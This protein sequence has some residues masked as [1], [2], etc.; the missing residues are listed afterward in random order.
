MLL[1]KLN[2]LLRP[3]SPCP[4]NKSC[5][6]GFLNVCLVGSESVKVKVFD[7]ISQWILISNTLTLG[8]PFLGV[9]KFCEYTPLYTQKYAKTKHFTKLA[10]FFVYCPLSRQKFCSR[11][12]LF[13]Y[14]YLN[15]HFHRLRWLKW[16]IAKYI[17]CLTFNI[18][19]LF[20]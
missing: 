11:S 4:L 14:F 10:F 3:I 5:Y 6:L 8:G 15:L 12:L 7:T 20:S 17:H 2:S 19:A 13:S 9:S 18:L 16:I 1:P